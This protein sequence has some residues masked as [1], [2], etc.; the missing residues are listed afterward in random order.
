MKMDKETLLKHRFWIGMI[1]FAPIWL[2]ILIIALAS[3]GSAADAKKKDIDGA[4]TALKGIS[5]PKN[6]KYTQLVAEKQKALEGQKDKVWAEAWKAQKD[7]M[8]WPDGIDGKPQLEGGYFGD[9]LSPAQRT[10][11]RDPKNYFGQLPVSDGDGKWVAPNGEPYIDKML[12]PNGEIAADWKRL[13]HKVDF[14]KGDKDPTD[15]ECWLAQEDIWVQREMLNIVAAALG[16]A[17]YFENVA[18]FKPVEIP[19]AELDK[20]N[21][22]PAPAPAGGTAPA[23]APAGTDDTA[24]KPPVVIR[25]RFHNPHWRLDLVMELNDKKELSVG[26][27]T[28]LTSIDAALPAPGI[29]IQ[30]WQ[31]S[32]K[33]PQPQLLHFEGGAAGKPLALAKAVALP[34]FSSN[35]DDLPLDVN[36]AADK[37]DAATPEGTRRLRFRNPNWELEL[38]VAKKPGEEASISADSKLTNINATRRTLALG[39]AQ[40]FVYQ[41]NRQLALLAP[42]GEWL[43]WTKT[44]PVLK[45]SIP[46]QYDDKDPAPLWVVQVF[47]PYTSP[48][49]EIRSFEIPGSA[50]CIAFNSQRTSNLMLKPAS[51]FPVEKK[52][53]SA[54]GTP[55]PG[56]GMAG[57]AGM[58]GGSAGMMGGNPE[59]RGGAAGAGAND[60]NTTPNGIRRNRYIAVTDQVRHMPVAMSLVVE[61][62]HL[63]D[64]LTA[65]A[66]SRLRIQITQV[67][68]KRSEGYKR[69]TMVASAPAPGSGGE[70]RPGGFLG[71]STSGPPMPGSGR[72][73]GEVRP[74]GGKMSGAPLMMPGSGGGPPGYPGMV[75]RGVMMPPMGGMVSPGGM[76]GGFPGGFGSPSATTDQSDPNLIEVAVYGIAALYERYPPKPPA[77]PQGGT[78]TTPAAGTTQPPK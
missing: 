7:L 41:G 8:K 73:P 77:Q 31:N 72:G 3:S 32:S 6:E 62:S 51:Q 45:K 9:P 57:M 47:N 34:G 58:I 64:L 38:L 42:P 74:G 23:P 53:E 10:Q 61:Q 25:Q 28:A 69:G 26:T 71:G 78:G 63:Q 75:G 70:A 43:A 59:G 21:A 68:W 56:G 20:L 60:P 49:A 27:Q 17:S 12:A 48:I 22:P 40:F 36:V 33:P 66:N 5:N 18:H 55:Q 50:E 76:G 24:K 52:E 19:K 35:F 37:S 30:L 39:T 44:T 11:F 4:D 13:L 14:N 46:I 2:L 67:Q 16:S 65:V 15:E 29:D 1:A 54:T